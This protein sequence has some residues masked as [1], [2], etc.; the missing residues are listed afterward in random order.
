[1]RHLQT[2]ANGNGD[3][4][5]SQCLANKAANQLPGMII[6]RVRGWRRKKP[7]YLAL[8]ASCFSSNSCDFRALTANSTCITVFG[9]VP[10]V[11]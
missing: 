11:F 8:P 4:V 3:T 9:N 5:S 10:T 7:Q 2:L 1:M 6:V